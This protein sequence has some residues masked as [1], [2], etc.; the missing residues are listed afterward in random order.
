[1]KEWVDILA[2]LKGQLSDPKPMALVTVIQ[3]EGSAY[4][5]VG[6]RMLVQAD[7]TWLGSISGG[8]L[9]G[10]ML[11]K[12]RLA[13]HQSQI[14]L[15]SYDTREEDPFAL[16]IGLGCNGKI[17]LL[18][19]PHLSNIQ[20]FTD[21]MEGLLR[22]SNPQVLHSHWNLHDQVASYTVLPWDSGMALPQTA[23]EQDSVQ[24]SEKIAPQTRLWVFG[25]QFDAHAL[26][27]AAKALAWELHWV[28]RKEKMEA[29]LRGLCAQC[30]DWEDAMEFQARDVL[31][32][33]SHDLDRD[34]ELLLNLA[35]QLDQVAYLG[36]LGPKKRFEKLLDHLQAHGQPLA[37]DRVHAPIGLDLG[38]EGPEEIALSILSEIIAFKN[39]KTPKYLKHKNSPIHA[40]T[41]RN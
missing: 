19:D 28:G 11:K 20:R 37:L 3:V 7:G 9:E 12:A 6:A 41:P 24:V 38:A 30:Y 18:I 21:I 22:H 35:P 4:R 32:M 17:D 34:K 31:V 15:V 14:K 36:I 16:G 29:S 27:R 23:M 25:H 10:D 13:I 26:L 40:S 39:A 5:R 8:C 1:M 33:M 2:H